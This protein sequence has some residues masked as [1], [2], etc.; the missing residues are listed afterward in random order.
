MTLKEKR[1]LVIL[2]Q[3][4]LKKNDINNEEKYQLIVEITNL[5]KEIYNNTGLFKD[6]IELINTYL[7]KSQFEEQN[8]ADDNYIQ[9]AFNT[10]RKAKRLVD[11]LILHNH[12]I[13]ERKI[14]INCYYQYI[15][16]G[17]KLNNR[18]VNKNLFKLLYNCK[19]V[20]YNTQLIDDLKDILRTYLLIAEIY[21]SSKK[22]LLSRIFYKKALKKMIVLYDEFNYEGMKEDIIF[23]ITKIIDT[24]RNKKKKA[25]NKWIDLIEEYGGNYE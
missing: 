5:L 24:F 14:F 7:L 8:M 23:I 19:L 13:Y 21:L 10:I 15:R 3:E 20:Y 11:E 2:K 17:N 4:E 16:L 22:R 9:K 1:D 18:K 6:K 12:N 25:V